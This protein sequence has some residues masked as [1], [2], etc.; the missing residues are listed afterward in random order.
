LA[1][2]KQTRFA[3]LVKASG[4]PHPATL[5][6]ADPAKDPEFKKAIDDNRI[7]TLHHVNVGTKKDSGEIGFRKG[8]NNSYLIFPKALPLVEGTAVIGIKFDM[9][10]DAPVK[11]P[12]K[13]KTARREKKIE[14]VKTVKDA[15]EPEPEREE[16]AEPKAGKTKAEKEKTATYCVSLEFT[17]K[18][19]E[20]VEVEAET[21]SEAM[22]IAARDAKKHP[23]KGV[24]WSVEATE[25]R[26]LK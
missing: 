1:A 19:S 18:A 16:K 25:V 5:W 7:V 10:E 11:D 20:L 8:T 24:D 2:S 26:K 13:V 17:A 14:R 4:R 3:N 21:A 15:P 6:V 22:E 9:L 23:P 12:V